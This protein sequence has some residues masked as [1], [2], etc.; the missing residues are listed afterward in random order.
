MRRKRKKLIQSRPRKNTSTRPDRLLISH[1]LLRCFQGSTNRN[2]RTGSRLWFG[3]L[4]VYIFRSLKIGVRRKPLLRDRA[5]SYLN[6]RFVCGPPEARIPLKPRK[7]NSERNCTY[8]Y[9]SFLY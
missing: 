6:F 3:F 2:P 7:N 4:V 1:E 5:P 8:N 9:D